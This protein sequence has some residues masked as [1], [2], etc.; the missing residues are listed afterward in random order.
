MPAAPAPKP[1][2][3][4]SR[5]TIKVGMFDGGVD[6][7]VPH[8]HGHVEEDTA[9]SIGTVPT[10]VGLAHGTAVAGALLYGELNHHAPAARL[11]TP[12]VSV[13]SIRALPTSNPADIDMYESIDVIERAVAAR[14]DIKVFNISFGPRGPILEDTISRFTYTLDAL[15]VAHRVAFV[16]AV[17]NDGE[18]TGH[19]R[20]QS[21]SDLV[22]GLGVGA[23]SFAGNA[24]Q[25]A[26]YSC[27]GPGREC[28]KIKPDVAAFGGCPNAPFHLLSQQTGMKVLSW[29]TSFACPLVARVGAQAAAAFD[30]STPLL[31]RALVVHGA[32]HP[33]NQPD[34]LLGHGCAPRD[35]ADVLGCDGQSVTVVFQSDIVPAYSVRLPIPLPDTLGTQGKV[36]VRWTVAGLPPIDPNHPADYTSACVED[37]FY[38]NDRRYVYTHKKS[39]KTRVLDREHDKAEVA[40]LVAQGWKPSA[41]P[42]TESGN[43]YRYESDRR[44]I[45]CQWEPLVRREVTKLASGMCRPF[46]TLHAIG[47]NRAPQ[48]FDYAVVVTVTAPKYQGD[49][50][51]DI[52]TKY[53][54][55]API[56]VRTEAEIRVN[57]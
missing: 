2:A 15:A 34:A 22:H 9:L 29:G 28:G 42:Q 52:R 55:L 8:L 41:L 40:K 26:A 12:P 39:K 24:V 6:L 32:L 25:H 11:P 46:L 33:H 1:P 7:S 3:A 38:P 19:D 48:R 18:M 44:A 21:P 37:T 5:S 53:P 50:Y 49:L 30:R 23:H 56:R 35:V 47:R 57:F 17:G 36:H 51:T 13:V 4:L 31:A 14:K 54:A 27:K 10:P 45:D 43:T 16:V 20:I